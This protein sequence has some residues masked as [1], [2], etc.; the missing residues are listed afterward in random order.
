MTITAVAPIP[1]TALRPVPYLTDDG[2]VIC[3]R[4]GCPRITRESWKEGQLKAQW[5]CA[6]GHYFMLPKDLKT[7][8][9]VVVV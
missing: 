6:D 9:V 5:K 1:S 7:T 8:W 2:Q 3:P 4:C